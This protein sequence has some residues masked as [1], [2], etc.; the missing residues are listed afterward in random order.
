MSKT[1]LILGALFMFLVLR[2]FAFSQ[3]RYDTDL[4]I[5]HYGVEL[6]PDFETNSLDLVAAVHIRN[7]SGKTYD[8]AE[9]LWV[10][11]KRR[12]K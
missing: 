7:L 8:K 4:G 3:E 5:T 11:L 2:A 10:K 12:D 6:K 1:R 9:D